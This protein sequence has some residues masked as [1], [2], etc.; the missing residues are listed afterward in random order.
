MGVVGCGDCLMRI[1]I[2]TPDQRPGRPLLVIDPDG[3][4]KAER[5]AQVE[6]LEESG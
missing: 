5:Y 4:P 6:M 1:S 2:A 3:H